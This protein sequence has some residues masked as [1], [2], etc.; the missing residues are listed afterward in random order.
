MVIGGGMAPVTVEYANFAVVQAIVLYLVLFG[1]LG[2]L[3]CLIWRPAK[4]NE[5]RS[6]PKAKEERPV[7]YRHSGNAVCGS[8][9]ISDDIK[10][11]TRSV[12]DFLFD[13]FLRPSVSDMF[14]LRLDAIL[15]VSDE[16]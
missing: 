11:T 9:S 6:A 8:R 4:K 15:P 1:F 13:D 3:A 10:T 2:W 12:D 5:L 7:V 14:S 16:D